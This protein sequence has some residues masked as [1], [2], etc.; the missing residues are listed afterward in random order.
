M[1]GQGSHAEHSNLHDHE[2]RHDSEMLESHHEPTL[3]ETP[4][5]A[6]EIVMDES[7]G[8]HEDTLGRHGDANNNPNKLPCLMNEREE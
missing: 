2:E 6:Q 1:V 3:L 4:L 8:F 5:K 7:I